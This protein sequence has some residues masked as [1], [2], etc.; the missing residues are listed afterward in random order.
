MGENPLRLSGSHLEVGSFLLPLAVL[1]GMHCEASDGTSS[2]SWLEFPIQSRSFISDCMCRCH[3][4]FQNNAV[5]NDLE[6]SGQFVWVKLHVRAISSRSSALGDVLVH[7][8]LMR[9]TYFKLGFVLE[10][11]LLSCL[12]THSVLF[13]F[14]LHRWKFVL[15]G[16]DRLYSLSE[17]CMLGCSSSE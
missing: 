13:F 1:Q 6:E 5:T 14:R 8:E 15:K 17:S 16:V 2:Q 10:I 4:L 3:I 12:W 7:Y 9:Y 11:P